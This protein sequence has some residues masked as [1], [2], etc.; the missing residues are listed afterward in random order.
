MRR[1]DGRAFRSFNLCNTGGHVVAVAQYRWLMADVW[2][3]AKL[4][5]ALAHVL[6]E[7]DVKRLPESGDC[8]PA[9]QAFHP[10]ADSRGGGV[11]AGARVRGDAWRRRDALG[12]KGADVRSTD[13]LGEGCERS[14]AKVLEKVLVGRRCCRRQH[15]VAAAESE[16]RM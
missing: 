14:R 16:L 9:P 12:V 5:N 10:N 11:L 6:Q 7:R 3:H 4:S 1:V 15:D 13:N 2:G 8:P